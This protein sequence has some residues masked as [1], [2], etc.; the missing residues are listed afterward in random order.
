M[1]KLT[2]KS[3]KSDRADEKK[4][5]DKK[6]SKRDKTENFNSAENLAPKKNDSLDGLKLFGIAKLPKAQKMNNKQDSRNKF[7]KTGL[8]ASAAVHVAKVKSKSSEIS[9][10]LGGKNSSSSSDEILVPIS[11]ATRPRTN[12]KKINERRKLHAFSANV[13]LISSSK[14]RDK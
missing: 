2:K 7:R 1:K 10:D 14:N 3:T 4:S 8:V 11:T 12:R 9:S 6:K 13:L 5:S